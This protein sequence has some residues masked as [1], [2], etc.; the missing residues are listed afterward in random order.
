MVHIDKKFEK[1]ALGR[2]IVKIVGVDAGMD[3][4]CVGLAL[5]NGS[6]LIVLCDPE[7]NGPGYVELVDKDGN[8]VGGAC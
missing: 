4:N 6:T 5:D 7:G 3:E 1:A 2:K 8:T